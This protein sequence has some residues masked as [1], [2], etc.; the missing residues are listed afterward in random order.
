[1]VNAQV[2]LENRRVSRDRAMI[3]TQTEKTE[4]KAPGKNGGRRRV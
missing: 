2:D 3:E 1:M 4:K